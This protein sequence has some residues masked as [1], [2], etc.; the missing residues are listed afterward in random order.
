MPQSSKPE[1]FRQL[2]PF[3]RI[4]FESDIDQLRQCAAHE[5]P[6]HQALFERVFGMGTD[7]LYKLDHSQTVVGVPCPI[8][9]DPF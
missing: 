8:E 7:L 4:Q 2:H 6:G 3:N 1:K 5:K 9:T